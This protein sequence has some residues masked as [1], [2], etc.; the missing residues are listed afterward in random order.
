MNELKPCAFCGGDA[1]IIDNRLEWYVEC[2]GCGVVVIG[3]RVP[4]PETE[5]DLDAIDWDM[6]KQ[7]ASEAWNMVKQSASEAWNTRHIPK[8]YQLVPIEP[9]NKMSEA[10]EDTRWRWAS[11]NPT[12]VRE[13]YKRMLKAAGDQDE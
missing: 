4:E 13:I 10:G 11:I 12:C 9:T 6:V 5:A 1:E 2:T 3:D 8:G 7:S